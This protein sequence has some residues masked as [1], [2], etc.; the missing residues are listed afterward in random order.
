MLKL[1]NNNQFTVLDKMK[2]VNQGLVIKKLCNIFLFRNKPEK[3][4]ELENKECISMSAGD[5]HSLVL[6]KNEGTYGF[7]KNKR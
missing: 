1:M 2:K 5:R 3:V 6:I 7:G 4:K